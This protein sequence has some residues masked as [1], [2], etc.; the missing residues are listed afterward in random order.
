MAYQA[1]PKWLAMMKLLQAMLLWW[2]LM[3]ALLVLA[4][5]SLGP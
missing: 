3:V 2:V 4:L 5:L 1:V